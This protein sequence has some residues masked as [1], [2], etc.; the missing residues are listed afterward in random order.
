MT[1]VA[2]YPAE[3]DRIQVA[4]DC[5]GKNGGKNACNDH[6]KPSVRR[7]ILEETSN[8]IEQPLGSSLGPRPANQTAQQWDQQS[9]ADTLRQGLQQPHQQNNSE[10][11]PPAAA[12]QRVEV[13]NC[14]YF[15]HLLL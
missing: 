9:D 15:I 8:L 5:V 10:E 1:D 12:E 7:H 13:L 6:R 3:Q 2:I 11:S 14:V 4:E